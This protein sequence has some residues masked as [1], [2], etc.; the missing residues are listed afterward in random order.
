MP[1]RINRNYLPQT[2]T[3]AY[4]WLTN[5]AAQLPGVVANALGITTTQTNALLKATQLLTDAFRWQKSAQALA[6]ERTGNKNEALWNPLGQTVYVR[7]NTTATGPATLLQAEAG[8]IPLAVAICDEILENKTGRLD[9]ALR[10]LLRL[11]PLPK[12]S[13]PA[14]TG[15]KPQ[16]TALIEKNQLTVHFTK[17]GYHYFLV[18][19]DH[20]TGAFDHEYPALESPFKDPAPLP[21]ATPQLWRVQ[22]LGYAKGATI[23]IP[24][25]IIDVAAKS[26]A[27][28]HSEGAN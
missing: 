26:Y 9:A 4:L 15:E 21:L 20:G 27:A 3:E 12:P 11:N 17:G 25:D 22:L 28:E 6:E 19:I 24:G 7:P 13:T 14:A 23:G 10:E 16:Y 2:K 1:K 18:K 8:A 5:L